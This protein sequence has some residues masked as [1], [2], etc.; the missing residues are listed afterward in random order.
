[1]VYESYKEMCDVFAKTKSPEIFGN[2]NCE[3][4]KY[5]INNLIINTQKNIN[6]F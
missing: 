1:M 4:A 5:I 2:F 6:I 3:N